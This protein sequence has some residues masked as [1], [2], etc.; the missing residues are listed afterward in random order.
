MRLVENQIL[1]FSQLVEK[2]ALNPARILQVDKGTLR[3]G[4]DADLIIVD[5]VREF[6]ADP[7][8]FIS[9]GKNTPFKGWLLRGMPVFT[10]AGGNI[11]EW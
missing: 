11:Y 3:V 2:M 4:A 10:I 1:T 7:E 9:K 8:K 5:T 6:R